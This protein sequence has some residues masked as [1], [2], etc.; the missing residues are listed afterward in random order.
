M[1]KKKEKYQPGAP[2]FFSPTLEKLFNMELCLVWM[3]QSTIWMSIQYISYFKG[4]YLLGDKN[5]GISTSENCIFLFLS[6]Q[7]YDRD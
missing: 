1:E 5:E 6:D 7:L 2:F 4:V 3:R